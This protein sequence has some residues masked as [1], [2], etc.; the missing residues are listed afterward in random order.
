MFI[1]PKYKE[2]ISLIP[3]GCPQLLDF[4]ADLK[5]APRMRRTF[6]ERRS[7][8]PDGSQ[9]VRLFPLVDR[10]GQLVDALEGKPA[11]SDYEL[12]ALKT[13]APW[14][15]QWIPLPFLREREQLWEDGTECRVEYGPTNWAR[16]RLV[17]SKDTPDTLRVV[18]AFDMLVGRLEIYPM[19][20]LFAPS[21]WKRRRL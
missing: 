1:M 4:A 16:G 12:D 8:A 17:M 2:R 13:L 21:I 20:L 6:E 7:T 9:Q 3:G 14:L 11:R 19:L 18:L 10:D 15:G 5:D